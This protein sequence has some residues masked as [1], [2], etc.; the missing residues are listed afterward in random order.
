MLAGPKP[1]VFTFL[2][3]TPDEEK[4][5]MLVNLGAS[6]VR[7]GSDV[8][9]LDASTSAQGVAARLDAAHGAS[10]MDVAR[11]ERALSEVVQAMSQGFGVARLT[12]GSQRAALQNRDQ[13]RRLANTF[14]VLAKQCDIVVIDAELDEDDSLPVP[15]MAA[16]EIVVQ[17]SSR[18]WR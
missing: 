3:A 18:R 10:L 4:S 1:R 13:A 7:A 9:L 16:G 17:V 8:L 15:A 11:Q 12:H 14:D 5:A 2:S 6:L